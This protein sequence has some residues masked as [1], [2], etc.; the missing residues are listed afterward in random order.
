MYVCT[1]IHTYIYIYIYICTQ[2]CRLQKTGQLHSLKHP[3]SF[4]CWTLSLHYNSNS[5][6]RLDTNRVAS[7]LL[8]HKIK[9]LP[10]PSKGNCERTKKKEK[11]EKVKSKKHDFQKFSISSHLTRIKLHYDL[12]ST[13]PFWIPP[14]WRII[15]FCFFF[16]FSLFFFLFFFSSI[17][18]LVNLLQCQID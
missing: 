11:R 12:Y 3:I 8:Q 4:T 13:S 7:C 14:T 18:F 17:V 9:A 6:S 15:K 5:S 2:H 1:Y 10:P 16:F